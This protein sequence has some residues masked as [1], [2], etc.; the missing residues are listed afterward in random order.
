MNTGCAWGMQ[1]C[2]EN[3]QG[4]EDGGKPASDPDHLGLPL[5]QENRMDH[6]TACHGLQAPKFTETR[7][8]WIPKPLGQPK[9]W[10]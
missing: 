7:A 1:K 10:V 6:E 3:K 8:N 2:T 5:L 9:Y 4:Q